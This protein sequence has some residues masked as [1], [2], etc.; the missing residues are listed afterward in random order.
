[1]CVCVTHGDI[2]DDT[3]V[4]LSEEL[5]ID[6]FRRSN[7]TEKVL[8]PKEEHVRC[9]NIVYTCT[10]RVAGFNVFCVFAYIHKL[11]TCYK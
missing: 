8:P 2:S 7:V 10:C 3:G 6:T 5:M 1:M 4:E 11:C 9:Y